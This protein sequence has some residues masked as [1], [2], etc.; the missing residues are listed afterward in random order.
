MGDLHSITNTNCDWS[1]GVSRMRRKGLQVSFEEITEADV[2]QLTKVTTRA[3]DD[4]A[5]K[6]RGLE[7]TMP[8]GTG[9]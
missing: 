4:D 1:R 9:A 6:H 8:T 2:P 7:S 3:F 5:R